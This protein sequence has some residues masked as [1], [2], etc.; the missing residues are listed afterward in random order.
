[1]TKVSARKCRWFRMK[2]SGLVEP[3]DDPWEASHAL[4]GVQ[5]QI[6]SAAAVSLFNRSSL[7]DFETFLSLLFEERRLIKLWGQR[8]TLHLYTDDDWPLLIGAQSE[9]TTW[10]ERYDKKRGGKLSYLHECFDAV[11]T[12]LREEKT[13]SRSQIRESSLTLDDWMLSSW[14]GLFHELVRRGDACH[15]AQEAGEGV[16]AHREHW[17]PELDWN[18]DDIDT[19][20]TAIARRYFRT[21]GPST[22][23]DFAY[24]RGCTMKQAKAW[25]APFADA[26]KEVS[27]DGESLWLFDDDLEELQQQPP[28]RTGWPVCVLYRFDPLLLAHKD[29]SW[30][31]DDKDYPQV[32][33][34][35]GHIEGNILVEGRI[36]GTWRYK[37]QSTVFDVQVYPF[38]TFSSHVE[39]EVMERIAEIAAFFGHDEAEVAFEEGR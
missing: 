22:I 38:S 28:A 25:T 16:F 33:R 34:K 21:Y 19:S 4:F 17:L 15:A 1:M 2:R 26:L 12:L 27:I 18:P 8:G 39:A 32:W 35:A 36:I 30:L 20:N 29:K 10:M 9:K 7:P 11:A 14:G 13:L 3:F 31:I 5:A 6:L 23:K 37:R 24:W